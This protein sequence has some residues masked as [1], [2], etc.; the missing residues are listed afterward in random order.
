MTMQIGVQGVDICGN[1]PVAR[2]IAELL[3]DFRYDMILDIV[4]QVIKCCVMQIKGLAI[5]TGHLRQLTHTYL[6][7][8]HPRTHIEK[9]APQRLPR[10]LDAKG[11]QRAGS[12]EI[13]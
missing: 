6:I 2:V 1:A 10:A 11:I 4:E 12:D 7:K 13:Y 9:S 8:R 3:T 5:H